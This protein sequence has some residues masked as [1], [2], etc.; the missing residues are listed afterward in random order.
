MSQ[1]RY[2]VY[3]HAT[4]GTYA[5]GGGH[6]IEPAAHF[7]Q[8]QEIYCHVQHSDIDIC[9]NCQGQLYGVY[10]MRM[11]LEL[12]HRVNRK[13][14]VQAGMHNLVH[15]RKHYNNRK[16]KTEL[17]QLLQAAALIGYYPQIEQFLGG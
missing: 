2:K 5:A 3:A 13:S 15:C 14:T 12:Y 6:E 16:I 11:R 4:R 8:E 1:G 7:I 17:A 9:I 10:T